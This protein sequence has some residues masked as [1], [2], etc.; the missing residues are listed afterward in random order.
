MITEELKRMVR[1]DQ[2]ARERYL[3][4]TKHQTW[5]P[6]VD[7]RNTDQLKQII[8]EIGWPTI[9]RVGKEGSSNAWLLAQHA[10]HD[11]QFQKRCL[12]LMKLEPEGEVDKANIAFL[13]DRLAVSE[14]RPQLYGTQFFKSPEGQWQPFQILDE[15]DIEQRRKAMGLETFVENQKRIQREH[16]KRDAR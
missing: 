4:D 5:D 16:D 15:K 1:E 14:E 10:D 13:E 9:S 3:S 11:P 8:E 7:R 2:S 12:K 6:G